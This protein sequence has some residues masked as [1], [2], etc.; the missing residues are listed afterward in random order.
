MQ[1][2]IGARYTRYKLV[3]SNGDRRQQFLYIPDRTLANAGFQYET[4]LADRKIAFTGNVNHLFNKKYWGLGNIG[5]G[6]TG[7][8]SAK[9][10]W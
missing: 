4:L 2:V 7:S 1:A 9:I 10:S 5:E 8:V 3:D 6:I